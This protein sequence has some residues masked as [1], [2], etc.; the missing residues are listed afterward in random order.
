[1]YQACAVLGKM[2]KMLQAKMMQ[3]LPNLPKICVSPERL[4]KYESKLDDVKAHPSFDSIYES[5]RVVS[6][7]DRFRVQ[8]RSFFFFWSAVRGSV[9]LTSAR[10]EDAPPDGVS[11]EDARCAL[12]EHVAREIQGRNKW[13]V[14]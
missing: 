9:C 7:G 5:Y 6:N 12:I 11:A 8:K 14:L 13:R 4:A 3:G 10:F 1:L 2:E